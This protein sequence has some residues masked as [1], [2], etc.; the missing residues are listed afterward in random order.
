MTPQQSAR[1]D[2]LLSLDSPTPA[3]SAELDDLIDL[4]QAAWEA[5]HAR[6]EF[7]RGEFPF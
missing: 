3:E 2:H 6:P 4:G 5:E 1:L 7:P